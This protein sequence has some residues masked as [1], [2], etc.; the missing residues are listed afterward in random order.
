MWYEVDE[1]WY[2]AAMRPSPRELHFI[3]SRLYGGCMAISRRRAHRRGALTPALARCGGEK[4]RVSPVD[5]AWVWYKFAIDPH[6]IARVV[7][8]VGDDSVA[9]GGSD[10]RSA[11]AAR[12][13]LAPPGVPRRQARRAV[14]CVIARLSSCGMAGCCG[15]SIPPCPLCAR[16]N[17]LFA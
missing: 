3:F 5:L 12:L 14:L 4:S 11:G 10:I 9:R 1:R 2:E 13:A 17:C 8:G 7:R 6:G 15:R 16:I